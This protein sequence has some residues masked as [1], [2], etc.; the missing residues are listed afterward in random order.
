MGKLKV[1]AFV[2]KP[3]VYIYAMAYPTLAFVMPPHID[4]LL[5]YL[6]VIAFISVSFFL[7]FLWEEEG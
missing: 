3:F 7:L 5:L 6:V 2:A 1:L 4:A